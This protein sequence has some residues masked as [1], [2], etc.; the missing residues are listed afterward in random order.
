MAE[1]LEAEAE[2]IGEMGSFSVPSTPTR[3]WSNDD[4]YSQGPKNALPRS[5]A[6]ERLDFLF[7]RKLEFDRE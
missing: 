1:E 2:L 3:D 5:L 7:R 4:H 6:F